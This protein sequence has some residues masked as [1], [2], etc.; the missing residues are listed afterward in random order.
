MNQPFIPPRQNRKLTRPAEFLDAATEA[1][2]ALSW[3]DTGDVAARNRLVTAHRSLALAAAKRAGGRGREI[4][5]DIL[6]QANIG[7][8]KAA[9]RFDPDRGFRFSTYA[10][11][12]IRAE[13]QEYTLQNWSLVRLPNQPSTRKLFYNL[14]RVETRLIDS[15]EVAPENLDAQVAKVLGVRPDQVVA[16]RQRLTGKDGSLNRAIGDGDSGMEMQDLLED[17]GAD[18]EQHVTNRLDNLVFWKSM[19][20]HLKAI[21]KREQEIIIEIYVSDSPKTL[22]ELGER[23]GI[24]NE[25]VRQIRERAIERLRVSFS[26]VVERGCVRDPV[27]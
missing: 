18:V 25:R 16:I 12:W 13:I 8:L 7:L 2:L 24:S 11:W 21:S 10:K 26:K 1:R 14:K 20:T 6:Q 19:A 22:G 15:G 3:R 23:F 5:D 4:D 9:D 17:P 27:R